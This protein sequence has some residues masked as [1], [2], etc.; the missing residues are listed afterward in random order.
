MFSFLLCYT[1]ILF[2]LCQNLNTFSEQKKN[3]FKIEL[4][5]SLNL[6]LQ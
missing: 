1:L 3:P 5:N 6:E 2:D 4:N